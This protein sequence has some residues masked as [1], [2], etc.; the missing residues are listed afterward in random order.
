M[1]SHIISALAATFALS[2]SSLAY[3]QTGMQAPAPETAKVAAPFSRDA[4][5]PS[6]VVVT[7][8]GDYGATADTQNVLQKINDLHPD[9]HLALGDLSYGQLHEKEWCGFVRNYVPNTPFLLLTGNH[10]SQGRD[11]DID[12]FAKCLP[13]NY[14]SAFT[15]EYPHEYYFDT[16]G[17][18]PLARFILISPDI[19]FK[20]NIR[21]DYNKGTTHAKWLQAAIDDARKQNIKWVIVGMHKVCMTAEKKSCEV[22]TDLIKQIIDNKV[23]VV[24]AGHVHAYERSYQL[25]CAAEN[26]FDPACVA[27]NTDTLKQGDGTIF[28]TQGT[29]GIAV[30]RLNPQDPEMP[31]FAKSYDENSGEIHGLGKLT[32]TDKELHHE[33]IETK[34]QRVIDE[35][36]IKK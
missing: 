32:I 23:D 5:S 30:R 6:Q 18:T 15:G 12:N 31:Y 29:G 9:F 10:E 34:D 16:P 17:K 13:Y 25:K 36:W 21:Y 28:I 20:N 1:R 7:F 33:F 14:K 2:A 22:G 24:M 26:S 35:F 19:T 27:N 11:G 4:S 3:A 8:A